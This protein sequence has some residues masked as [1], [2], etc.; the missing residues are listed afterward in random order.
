VAFFADYIDELLVDELDHRAFGLLI[1]TL[2]D[3]PSA[4]KID[5]PH[6]KYTTDKSSRVIFTDI[7]SLHANKRTIESDFS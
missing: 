3:S 6:R 5:P 1:G 2:F 4:P 7:N